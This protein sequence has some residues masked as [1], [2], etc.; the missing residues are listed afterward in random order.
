MVPESELAKVALIL[1][2]RVN[3]AGNEVDSYI[4][5]RGWLR[6]IADTTVE[7]KEAEVGTE[8]SRPV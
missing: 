5:V 7:Q 2:D 8:G 6:S 1:L 4:A 3:L